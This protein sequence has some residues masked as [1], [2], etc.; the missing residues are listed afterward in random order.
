[1]RE[2]RGIIA[3]LQRVY[4]TNLAIQANEKLLIV[5]DSTKKEVGDLFYEA[6]VHSGIETMLLQYEPT[7]RSGI[8]PPSFV[9][10]SMRTVD[11]AICITEHSISHTLARQT[12]ASS[13]TRVATMPGMTLDLLQNGAL[14]ANYEKVL[15]LGQDVSFIL[16]KGIQVVIRT[17]EK[18]LS[19]S[20]EDRMSKVSTGLLRNPGDSGNLP[21]GEAYIAPV[22]GTASGEITIDASIAEIG[23]LKKP[24]TLKIVGGKL[25]GADGSD[26]EKLLTLLGDGD[27]RLLCELG[28]G[29][30]QAARITGNVLEDEKKYGTCHI[31]FGSNVTFGGT[32]SAGVHID[33]VITQPEVW[34]DGELL[35]GGGEIVSLS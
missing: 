10:E 24:I 16:N 28:I 8:E 3:M 4:Q 29:T 31:A 6:G 13:G 1:M 5:I 35:V 11:I 9:A 19:F 17:G 30:N 26:G 7:G 34:I 27:G 21:S 18:Q 20:I 14:S 15:Q 25:V 22:E 32:V 2:N 12:A 23:L 33:C